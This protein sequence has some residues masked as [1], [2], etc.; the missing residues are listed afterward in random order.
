MEDARHAWFAPRP[1]FNWS[2]LSSSSGQMRLKK[3]TNMEE[4]ALALKDAPPSLL[5]S[6]VQGW[7]DRYV[8]FINCTFVIST[9]LVAVVVALIVIFER[10]IKK[11]S[12]GVKFFGDIEILATGK[13]TRG[14]EDVHGL[15]RDTRRLSGSKDRT[16][17]HFWCS[18]RL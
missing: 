18:T 11:Q 2:E 15:T 10:D 8:G 14:A 13:G 12:G 6:L 5:S 9:F 16:V 3:N 1:F 17:R 4:L 7:I